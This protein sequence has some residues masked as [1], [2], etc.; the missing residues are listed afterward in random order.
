MLVTL[1]HLT[2]SFPLRMA[3]CLPH[4]HS[5]GNLRIL[6]VH[7]KPI[8]G[9]WT[10][11]SIFVGLFLEIPRLSGPVAYKLQLPIDSEIQTVFHVSMMQR[12]HAPVQASTS[13]PQTLW[14]GSANNTRQNNGQ[15]AQHT[16]CSTLYSMARPDARRSYLGV[17][18]WDSS[19]FP[20]FC[21][22]RQ[23]SWRREYW[24]EF[25][26]SPRRNPALRLSWTTSFGAFGVS[27]RL[28]MDKSHST[29]MSCQMNSV[30]FLL[31]TLITFVLS[32]RSSF[33][34]VTKVQ[35]YQTILLYIYIISLYN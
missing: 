3:T 9:Y 26:S 5:E 15:E 17:C 27:R 32:C 10:T 29:M 35:P 30:F 11:W 2:W 31:S 18:R 19:V 14:L 22:W 1:V 23:G 16:C 6:V 20:W 4:G 28:V 21:T 33:Q 12:I 24:C 13:F 7:V 25:S 34:W 8:Y